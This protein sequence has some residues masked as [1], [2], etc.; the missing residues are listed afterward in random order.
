[1]V[2]QKVQMFDTETGELIGVDPAEVRPFGADMTGSSFLTLPLSITMLIWDRRS[3]CGVL[4][5][6]C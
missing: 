2:G 3:V 4:G 5:D 1:M 6:V